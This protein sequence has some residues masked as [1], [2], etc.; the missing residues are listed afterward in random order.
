[1][2]KGRLSRRGLPALP[3]SI[4]QFD[5]RF[6]R[7]EAENLHRLHTR[8]HEPGRGVHERSGLRNRSDKQRSTRQRF[9]AL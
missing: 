8:C 6:T 1:M 9:Y 3:P 7:Q 2:R 5:R 4:V